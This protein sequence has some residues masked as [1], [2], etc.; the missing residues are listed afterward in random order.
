VCFDADGDVVI[1]NFGT[2]VADAS[3]CSLVVRRCQVVPPQEV[4]DVVVAVGGAGD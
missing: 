4:S 2:N 3:P 1:A